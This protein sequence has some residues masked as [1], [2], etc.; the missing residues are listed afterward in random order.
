MAMKQT[1]TK[2]FDFSDVGLDFCVGSKNLFPDRFKKMLSLG[3]NV[4]TVTSVAV[5]G[6]QITFTYGGAHGYTADRVL[7]VDSGALASINGGEFWID[8]ATTNAVTFTLDN[9]PIS[10]PGNF[11]TRIASLGWQLV[12]ENA[13]IHVYKFKHI[14]DTDMYARFCF[15]TNLTQRNAVAVGIGRTVDLSLGVVTDEN[16]LADLATCTTLADATSRLYFNFTSSPY[17]GTA[18]NEFTYPQGVGTYGLSKVVG[19]LYHIVFMYNI[20]SSGLGCVSAILPFA[21]TYNSINLPLLLCQNFGTTSAEIN[22]NALGNLKAYIGKQNCRFTFLSG[23]NI[24]TTNIA[25]AS[26]LPSTIDSF[27]TTACMPLSIYTDIER[28]NIGNCSGGL[29]QACYASSNTP[30]KTIATTPAAT[31]DIDLNS[32]VLTQYMSYAGSDAWFAA[33]VEEIKIGA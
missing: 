28:Q 33:P 30:T 13:H 25:G 23:V 22:S 12:Y 6:N 14:D 24:A 3:Y 5:A 18:Q 15:Q 2:L 19:S 21:S 27:N 11:T 17:L 10:I 20:G 31:R 26:F 32:I 29:Y 8:S 9:A 16:C 4:Q 1:Q 7:K